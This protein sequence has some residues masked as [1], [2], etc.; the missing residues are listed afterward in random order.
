MAKQL[1]KKLKDVDL[2]SLRSIQVIE[3]LKRDFL[4]PEDVEQ[5]FPAEEPDSNGEY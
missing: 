4:Q 5:Q 2:V 1:E 3:V